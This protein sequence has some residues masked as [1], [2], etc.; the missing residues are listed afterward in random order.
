MKNY[1]E[2]VIR[3]FVGSEGEQE[4]VLTGKLTLVY[5]LIILISKVAI[6]TPDF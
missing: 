2:K 3:F 1:S 4:L 5:P 6:L